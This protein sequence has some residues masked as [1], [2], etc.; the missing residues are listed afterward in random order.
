MSARCRPGVAAA[1]MAQAS[2]ATKPVDRDGDHDDNKPDSAVEQREG[3]ARAVAQHNG[4]RRSV[5]SP[6]AISAIA[7]AAWHGSITG[8]P[9]ASSTAAR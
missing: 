9:P 4:E 1:Q 8:T 7:A 2:Q 3:N 6:Y 5:A